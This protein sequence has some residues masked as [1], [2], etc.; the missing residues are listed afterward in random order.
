MVESGCAHFPKPLS[1]IARFHLDTRVREGERASYSEGGQL[2]VG[3]Q[4]VCGKSKALIPGFLPESLLVRAPRVHQGSPYQVR[5]ALGNHYD[6]S[7]VQ[8]LVCSAI[9]VGMDSRA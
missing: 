5:M 2:P 9:P 3:H 6:G 7:I 4:V 8:H 1:H